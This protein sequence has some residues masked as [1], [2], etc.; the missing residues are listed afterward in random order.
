MSD[1]QR[2]I[3]PAAQ[4]LWD[5]EA[6]RTPCAPIRDLIGERDIDL[7]YAIQQ[8]N[9]ER[10]QQAGRRISGRKIGITAKSVQRQLNVF[11]PDFGTLF[12]DMEIG[13]GGVV[14]A[15]RLI[16]PQV[17]AEVMIV[18][19]RDLDH[20][21][22]T[23]SDVIRATDFAIASLEIV[24]C[25]LQDWD[26]RITDTV[27]DNAAAALYVVGALPRPIQGLDL[28]NCAMTL[29]RNGELVSEGRGEMCMG[30]PL[31]GAVWLARALQRLGTPLRAGDAILTG[32]L[33]PMV[34]AE[35][36]DR[37]EARIDGLGNVVAEFAA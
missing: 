28:A 30:H 17:E 19:G 31:N 6:N 1:Q 23:F 27:S 24:D 20:A 8:R 34:P 32:A 37:F 12:A 36:G 35:P 22:I 18:L 7:A 13:H 4:R 2:L 29:H 5:A 25:R 21:A 33:G 11:E 14:P 15:G 16:R 26:I 9:V 3:E 10:H